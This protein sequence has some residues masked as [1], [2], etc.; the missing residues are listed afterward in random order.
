MLSEVPG[1]HAVYSL[2]R[3]WEGQTFFDG[4]DFY[5]S[6][7]N[8][9]NGDAIWVNKSV[10]T[11][12]HLAYIDNNGK[13]ILRVDNFTNVP[14]NEKRDTVRITT[15]DSFPVGSVILLDALHL[16]YGCS[17]WP[18]FWTR[19]TK[20]PIGGEI[21]IVEI[22]NLMNH[23]QMAVHALS[24]CTKATT[25]QQTGTNNSPNCTNGTG[26]TVLETNLNSA[27]AAFANAQGGVWATQFDV[28]G[29][30]IWFWNRANLPSNLKNPGSSIDTSGW[31]LPSAA[32]PSS[33]CNISEHFTAQKLVLDITLC[34]DWAGVPSVYN[35]TCSGGTTGLCYT[36]NVI[37]AGSPRYDNAYFIINYVRV[38]TVDGLASSISSSLH[39][40]STSSTSKPTTVVSGS[41]SNAGVVLNISSSH[42]F[43]LLCVGALAIFI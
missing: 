11:T 3:T 40:S 6:Y 23:N 38:Y 33:T 22:V 29:A 5:G 24:G 9:T 39:H 4:W 2:V 42:L 18:A 16:P 20:W 28:S 13:A 19:G 34:G 17:V 15:Q 31:G 1:A 32:Y 26:C 43:F 41:G 30:S 27:G 21:D 7:D 37:G 36:D 35:A 14:Y 8:L 10:A 25:S 12:G